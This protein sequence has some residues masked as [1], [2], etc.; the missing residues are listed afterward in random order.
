MVRC[1]SEQ[2]VGPPG[3]AQAG[4]GVN[5]LL[6]LTPEG[7]EIEQQGFPWRETARTGG[8]R[9]TIRLLSLRHRHL[10][11]LQQSKVTQPHV[12]AGLRTRLIMEAAAGLENVGKS[13]MHALELADGFKKGPRSLDTLCVG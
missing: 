10:S 7:P 13:L 12:A 11:S 1:A 2:A 9:H 3:D 5:K 8:D 6:R 4:R